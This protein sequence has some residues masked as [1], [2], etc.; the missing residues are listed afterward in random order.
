MNEIHRKGFS[1]GRL[2]STFQ[3]AFNFNLTET[4]S[5]INAKLFAHYSKYFKYEKKDESSN[6]IFQS[7][8]NINFLDFV[9]KVIHSQ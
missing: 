7:Y 4:I 5:T 6:I 2:I 8:L 3:E 1:S 9:K